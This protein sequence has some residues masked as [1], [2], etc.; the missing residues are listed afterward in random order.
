MKKLVCRTAAAIVASASLAASGAGFALYQGSAKGI[1]WGG[2]VMGRAVDGSANFY[3][4]A[5]ISDFTNVIVTVGTGIEIPRASAAVNGK[6]EGLMDPGAFL[7]PHAYVVVPL[8][9]D[10]SFGLG[11]APEYGLGS[12]YDDSWAM[13]W[14][15]TETLVEGIVLNPNLAYRVTDDWSVSAG[16]R[17]LYFSFDQYSKPLAASG[18][19]RL[20]QMST[21]IEGDNGYADW[22]WQVSTRYRILDNLSLGL[23]YRS[24]IDTK[25]R[26]H[27]STHLKSLN[28]PVINA[29]APY[30]KTTPDQIMGMVAAGAMKANGDAGADIR[31]PQS[32]AGGLNWTSPT[33]CISAMR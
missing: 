31:L 4:P 8:P 18:N 19:Y 5:T 32:I 7:L 26:G 1:A 28:T 9:F 14:N 10:F 15:T 6:G 25:V 27:Y 17:I 23:M 13:N 24:Y 30:L 12:Q 16:F 21:H 11:V 22:G 29:I 3:N 2:A 20:G 33:L